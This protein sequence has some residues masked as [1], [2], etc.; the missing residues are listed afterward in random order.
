MMFNTCI[1][2][3]VNISKG[4]ELMS[5]HGFHTETH[6]EDF[7]VKHVERFTVF[8]FYTLKLTKRTLP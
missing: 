5:G 4:F 1:K 3:R 7:S 2:F 6:K 8:F